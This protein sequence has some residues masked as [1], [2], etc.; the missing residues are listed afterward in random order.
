[1]EDTTISIGNQAFEVIERTSNGVKFP[2]KF[3]DS[4]KIWMSQKEISDNLKVTPQAV[5][6]QI[7]NYR[8]ERS[9]S[10]EEE[11]KSFYI[12]TEDGR[13]RL[14]EHYS[15][16]VLVFVG[17]RSKATTETVA[18]QRWVDEIIREHEKQEVSKLVHQLEEQGATIN[19][20]T[21]SNES[22][23]NKTKQLE[24]SVRDVTEEAAN[25]EMISVREAN[26]EITNT[27]AAV[28]DKQR[29]M[30]ESIARGLVKGSGGKFYTSKNVKGEEVFS[31]Q[32]LYDIY[33]NNSQKWPTLSL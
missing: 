26:I 20:L 12:I 31:R 7:R 18:L 14:V 10:T 25:Y 28:P 1:M 11:I 9:N 33:N 22:L 30:I 24:K 5:S 16:S 3:D 13:R 6:L 17:F 23:T 21:S 27:M 32:V 29:Q 15:L 8:T 4:F 2:V 19:Y